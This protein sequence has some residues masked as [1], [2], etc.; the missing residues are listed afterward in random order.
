MKTEYLVITGRESV[1][2]SLVK[3]S[4]TF[5]FLLFCIWVSRGSRSWTVVCGLLFFVFLCGKCAAQFGTR[6]RKFKTKEELAS[7]ATRAE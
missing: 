2:E 3:D 5:G 6:T 1:F 7:W 4:I